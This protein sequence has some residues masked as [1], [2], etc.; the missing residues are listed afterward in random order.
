MAR[1]KETEIG[2]MLRLCAELKLPEV[3]Q[4]TSYGAPSIK[5]RG[6]NFA[7]VRGPDEMVLHCPLEQ[8]ELL[9]EMAPEIYWQTDHFKG[10]PGLL[11][12]LGVIGDEELALR[13]E[14][15][16]RFRAP[17]RLADAYAQSSA[18]A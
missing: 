8:K 12:R 15:A 11:V 6:K 9:M 3:I 13:L 1:T 18:K 4:S 17:K 10:W 14:D 2:R 7:S 5:V 16:W